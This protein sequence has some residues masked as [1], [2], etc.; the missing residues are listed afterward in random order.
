LE[1]LSNNSDDGD[2]NTF[3]DELSIFCQGQ[4]SVASIAKAIASMKV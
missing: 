4:E 2:D 3:F 1:I